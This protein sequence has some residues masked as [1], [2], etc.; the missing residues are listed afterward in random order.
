MA[1]SITDPG[2]P[3]SHTHKS[4]WALPD[5]WRS[6][7]IAQL[8]HLAA[9]QAQW[10]PLLLERQ[11]NWQNQPLMKAEPYSSQAALTPWSI[12]GQWPLKR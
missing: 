11:Q 9:H 5:G 1:G 12:A 10:R 8:H 2:L 3:V 6:R 4:L 7:W